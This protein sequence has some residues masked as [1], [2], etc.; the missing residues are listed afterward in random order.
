MAN[1]NTNASADLVPLLQVVYSA[2]DFPTFFDAIGRR[3]REKFPE[4]YNDFQRTA[5][6]VMLWH[7]EAYGL[8]QLSFNLDRVAADTFLVTSRTL[9]AATRHTE[10]LNYKIP[11]ASAST[12][13]FLCSV[14]PDDMIV[15]STL[16]K[17]HR[18]QAPGNRVYIASDDV[19]V[20]A[21]ASSFTVP[22]TEGSSQELSFKSNGTA[23]QTFFLSGVTADE[24]FVADNSVVVFVDGEQWF[25]SD[26]FTF[27]ATNQFEVSYTSDPPEVRFG[28]GFA[29]NIPVVD[30]TIDIQNRVISGEDGNIASV[31][32][33]ATTTISSVDPFLVAGV[34]VVLVVTAPDGTSGGTPPQDLEAVKAIAPKVFGSR[35]VAVTQDDYQALVNSFSDPTFGAVAQGYAADVRNT[36]NDAETLARTD[37]ILAAI[38]A[39]VVFA[40][41]TQLAVN[42]NNETIQTESAS[43]VSEV[44][45]QGDISAALGGVVTG[46]IENTT[47]ITSSATSI[48]SAAELSGALYASIGA[49]LTESVPDLNLITAEVLQLKSLME[50]TITPASMTVRT[51]SAAIVTEAETLTTQNNA[52]IASTSAIETSNVAIAAAADAIVTATSAF[53]STTKVTQ[54]VIASNTAALLSHLDDLFDSDCQANVVNVPILALGVDGFYTGPSSG[55]IQSVQEYLDG[56][57]EV[58]QHVNVLSG[59]DSLVAADIV[60][61]G[62]SSNAF[63]LSEVVAAIEAQLDNILRGRAFNDPLYLSKPDT[64]IGLYDIIGDIDGL[65]FV[66]VAITGPAN[67]LDSDGNLVPRELEVI[68]KGTIDVQVTI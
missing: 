64:D 54:A 57:K 15:Q 31:T 1:P 58:T 36:G 59:A 11:P 67:R 38:D 20:P 24:T 9:A 19:I 49:E 56:I 5:V 47:L 12:G 35:G 40:T 34:A 43:I 28:D 63:Q 32:D 27:D 44:S 55:L 60:V 2:K 23:N 25:E 3:V 33:E 66:N 65:E 7:V 17:G 21:S 4:D 50:D 30:A 10:Q 61:T 26:F 16:S 62:K 8:S 18:F 51:T 68:T 52:L 45:T 42:T 48:D 53:E 6:A 41:S 39:L 46:L 14:D 29:G 22:V 37:T 13:D